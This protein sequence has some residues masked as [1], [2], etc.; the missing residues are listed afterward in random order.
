MMIYCEQK[1]TERLSYD[2][3]KLDCST[4]IVTSA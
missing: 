3:C 4:I 2:C 1:E